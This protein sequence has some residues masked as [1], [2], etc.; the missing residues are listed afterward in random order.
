[1]KQ[2]TP[3]WED[4]ICTLNIKDIDLFDNLWDNVDRIFDP[5]IGYSPSSAIVALMI[6]TKSITYTKTPVE[7]CIPT[8]Y[9]HIVASPMGETDN[10]LILKHTAYMI[11]TKLGADDVI[12]EYNYWD[13]Y[14]NK[15][16]IR[17][18]CGHTDPERLI[19]F[20]WMDKYNQ[21]W[22]LSYP[23]IGNTHSIIH[24]FEANNK[25]NNFIK[26]YQNRRYEIPFMRR[27]QTMKGD[28]EN[29]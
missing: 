9:S 6:Q 18:E 26:L 24:K 16:K 25:T 8:N 22:V 2:Y 28:V 4:L 15:L 23:D 29:V 3:I 7:I 19:S 17:I 12:F 10:H 11:L 14:S 20:L 5:F 1:M 27:I 21:F 13:V